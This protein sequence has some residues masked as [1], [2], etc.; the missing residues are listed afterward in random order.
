MTKERQMLDKTK[1]IQ[2]VAVYAEFAKSGYRTEM[3]ITPDGFSTEGNL[4]P[5][6]IFRRVVSTDKP[7]KLWE[8]TTVQLAEEIAE[9]TT[10]PLAD[11][12][13]DTYVDKR[14]EYLTQIFEGIVAGG[15]EITKEP[16][17]IETSQNDLALIEK[18]ET[19]TKIVY[20]IN[21]SRRALGFPE[22]VA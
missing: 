10:K 11:S 4:V 8:T 17:L 3:F 14:L 1:H 22:K 7:K 5:A 16:I 13:K 2:G 19:P 9:P 15:W 12:D 21:Q 6:K 20:R 18:G